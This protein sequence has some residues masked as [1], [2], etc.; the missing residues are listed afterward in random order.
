MV[1]YFVKD[2]YGFRFACTSHL[3]YYDWWRSKLFA[4]AA[5]H[6]APS[7]CA[8]LSSAT[9]RP[10]APALAC[11]IRLRARLCRSQW[12]VNGRV[13]PRRV[14]GDPPPTQIFLPGH[15]APRQI[16]GGSQWPADRLWG[17]TD[18]AL[19]R[20]HGHQ[21]DGV[22]PGKAAPQAPANER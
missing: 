2:L 13:W 22:Q 3:I 16:P 7:Q 6:H 5:D 15:C 14:A 9:G 4:V 11:R 8:H 18:D 19:G 17:M 21:G 20:Y 10:E 12:E 1:H